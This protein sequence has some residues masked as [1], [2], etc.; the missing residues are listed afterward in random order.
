LPFIKSDPIHS[1]YPTFR[2]FIELLVSYSENHSVNVIPNA[3]VT[4]VL[5]DQNGFVVYWQGPNASTHL[6]NASHVINATGIVSYPKLPESF[7]PEECTFRWKHSR[8]TRASDLAGIRRLLVVGGGASAAE[9]LDRWLEVRSADDYAWLS[10]RSRL[11]AFVNPILGLDVHYWIWLPEQLPARLLGRRAARIPEAMNGTHVLPAIKKRLITRVPAIV[12][13]KDNFVLTA[14]G[15]KLKPDLVVFATGFKYTTEHLKDLFDFDSEGRPVV[16]CC[17]STRTP[18][19]FLL[20]F[21]FGRTFASPYIRGI[22]RDA[23]YIAR[24]IA[25]TLAG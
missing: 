7:D 17:E 19:L 16:C 5:R 6:L 18:G 23:K 11:K 10:L 9:V 3:E 20:G 25:K 22:A 14:S 21:K 8:D 4:H 24:K 12:E 1:T 13:Y 2:E 15:E